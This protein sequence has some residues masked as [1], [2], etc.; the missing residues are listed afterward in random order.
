ME[1]GIIREA[2]EEIDMLYA[3]LALIPLSVGGVALFFKGRKTWH[4]ITGMALFALAILALFL[5]PTIFRQAA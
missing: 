1:A 3:Y 4:K 5:I 2:R